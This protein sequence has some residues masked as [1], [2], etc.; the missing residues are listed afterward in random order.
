MGHLFELE[1]I[2]HFTE[3]A[4]RCRIYAEKFPAQ[5]VSDIIT[6]RSDAYRE[7]ADGYASVRE[8]YQGYAERSADTP[9]G[10]QAKMLLW[11]HD[12]PRHALL[13][14]HV[15]GK[16]RL[17]LDGELV[18][19]GHHPEDLVVSPVA[20]MPGEHEITAEV[21]TTRPGSFYAFYLRTHA[22][23]VTTDTEW[24]FVETRPGRRPVSSVEHAG[25]R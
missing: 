5:P 6:L 7:I 16:Y 19:Q 23:N 2:G 10:I 14:A 15:N 4:E 8:V 3:A 24:E 13:G 11:F 1:R 18:S 25:W 9:A 22:T 17:Y 21:A 12:D 20:V